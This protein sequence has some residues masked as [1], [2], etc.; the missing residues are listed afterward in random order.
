MQTQNVQLKIIDTNQRVWAHV[1]YA[2]HICDT[3]C[4]VIKEFHNNNNSKT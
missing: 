2:S 3:H 4:E 1:S